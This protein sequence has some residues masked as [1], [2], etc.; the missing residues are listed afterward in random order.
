MI[1]HNNAIILH[2]YLLKIRE[3]SDMN[4]TKNRFTDFFVG[5]PSYNNDKDYAAFAS[6]SYYV[7]VL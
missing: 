5:T 6:L 1:I 3:W 4:T 7:L 2:R